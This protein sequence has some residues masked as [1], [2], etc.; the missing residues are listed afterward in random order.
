MINPKTINMTIFNFS[1]KKENLILEKDINKE[2]NKKKPANG[3]AVGS[4][5]TPKRKKY[6]PISK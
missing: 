5:K 1:F 4:K 6:L 2:N 3:N